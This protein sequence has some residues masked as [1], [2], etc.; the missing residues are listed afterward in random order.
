MVSPAA[1]PCSDIRPSAHLHSSQSLFLKEGIL[2]AGQSCCALAANAQSMCR[3]S[4]CDAMS[5]FLCTKM[6]GL[7][8]GWQSCQATFLQVSGMRLHHCH[9]DRR[10]WESR[11]L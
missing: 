3:D 7:P 1:S 8:C 4:H 2:R 11:M 6:K 9:P 5:S 10:D